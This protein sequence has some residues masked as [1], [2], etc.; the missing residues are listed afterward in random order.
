MPSSR[1]GRARARLAAAALIAVCV[2]AVAAASSLAAR[3]AGAISPASAFGLPSAGACVRGR[4]L[5]VHLHQLRGVR[6]ATVTVSVDGHVFTTLRRSHVTRTI[7]LTGLPSGRF[8]LSLTARTSRGTRV[9]T[10]RTYHG[11]SGSHAPKI[12]KQPVSQT[13]PI[14]GFINLDAQAVANPVPLVVWQVSPDL[15]KTWKNLGKPVR[16]S[17]SD[18]FQPVADGTAGAFAGYEYRAVF[19]NAAGSAT[20]RAVMATTAV[21]KT[22][23][24]DGYTAYAPAGESFTTVS[25]DW[26]VPTVTCLGNLSTFTAQW[27]GIQ[28]DTSGSPAVVQDGTIEGCDGA[29]PAPDAAWY[30]LVGD[31][32][33]NGGGQVELPTSTY[34][35][36][37]G[38]HVAAMVSIANSEWT[39][40]LTDSSQSWTFTISEPQTSPPLPQSAAEILSEGNSDFGQVTFTHATATLA[41]R[42]DPFGS[43]FPM[44]AGVYLGSAPVEDTSPLEPGGEQFTDTWHLV[45]T[46]TTRRPAAGAMAVHC[47]FPSDRCRTD[48]SE[49]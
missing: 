14:G 44:Q 2:S 3:Q 5:V 29:Q 8:V 1:I 33:V 39:L 6:W 22:T 17:S 35:V 11:C 23:D 48:R 7:R 42:T 25:A 49:L 28:S 27:P 16:A 19:S 4:R 12:T 13:V 15:G 10:Q 24:F 40:A 21:T 46:A 45:S 47:A 9:R 30:E 26:T 18:I 41:G 38:D 34:P 36:Q 43:L 20:T 37:P 31:P 32:A